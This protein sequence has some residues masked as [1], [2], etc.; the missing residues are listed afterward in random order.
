MSYLRAARTVQTT[1]KIDP[2]KLDI[3]S[4]PK[5][6]IILRKNGMI[7]DTLTLE[8]R[9]AEDKMHEEQRVSE[10]MN[11]IRKRHEQYKRDDMEKEG[12]TPE[13]IEYA[14]EHMYDDQ[15]DYE[16]DYNSDQTESDYDSE[17]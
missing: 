7:E 10:I 5:G 15:D 16:E 13:E 4:L 8:Q 9:E 2:N 6:W 1:R 12:Y 17:Y 14:I 11:N 3:H